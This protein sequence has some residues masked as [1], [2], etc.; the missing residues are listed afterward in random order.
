ML[1]LDLL[2]I[3]PSDAGGLLCVPS[4]TGG[5][6]G[7]TLDDWFARRGEALDFFMGRFKVEAIIMAV[8]KVKIIK[9]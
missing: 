8:V 1:G 2:C 6:L 7:P 4:D 9:I 5:F 3:T